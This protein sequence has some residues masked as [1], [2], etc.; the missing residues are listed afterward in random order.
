MLGLINP[1]LSNIVYLLLFPC[2]GGH[3]SPH[4]SFGATMNIGHTGA[5]D[6][7]GSIGDIS[8]I[9]A[10]DAIGA[11]GANTYVIG[12]HSECHQHPPSV[13]CGR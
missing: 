13:G 12:S 9:G 3:L 10:T 4:C 1:P 6:S 8:V 7:N 11:F 5:I 2:L